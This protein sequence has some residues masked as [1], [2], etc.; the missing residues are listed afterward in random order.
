MSVIDY[1]NWADNASAIAIVII[2]VVIIVGLA[3][4]VWAADIRQ[5]GAQ[6]S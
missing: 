3:I 5:R 4:F 2:N 1:L 6:T